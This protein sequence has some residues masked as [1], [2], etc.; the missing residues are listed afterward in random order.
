MSKTNL[1]T[2]TPEQLNAL[3]AEQRGK[4][5]QLH[6]ELIGK[7]LSNTSQIRD[8]RRKIAQTLTALHKNQ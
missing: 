4:L 6:Q 7:R 8:V 2:Q 1:T 3:L 5:S